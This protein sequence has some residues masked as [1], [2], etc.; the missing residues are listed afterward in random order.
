[1]SSDFHFLVPESFHKQV[2]QRATMLTC[3]PLYKARKN[4]N[5]NFSANSV[6][7]GRIW[8]NFKS[9]KLLCMSSLPVSMKRIPSRT[10]EKKWQNRFSNHI[11]IV[12]I[13]PPVLEKKIF[14]GFLP[15]MGVAAILV[16]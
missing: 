1:M 2:A 5:I 3:E 7:H 15:F 6:V 10:T 4:G 9:S 14:E 12:K 8:S 11:T 16:M 13:G